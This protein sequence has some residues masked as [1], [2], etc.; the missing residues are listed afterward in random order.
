MSLKA[1]EDACTRAEL[2]GQPLPD[3][4]DFLEKNK[5]LDVVEFEE[6]EIR[7]AEVNYLFI[8]YN[9]FLRRPILSKIFLY[10][11]CY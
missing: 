5:H 6:V 2:F 8:Y 4:A 1:Y 9:N 10:A 11:W 3:K 7:T